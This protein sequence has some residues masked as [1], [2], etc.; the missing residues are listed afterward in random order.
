MP[1][2]SIASGSPTNTDRIRPA[3]LLCQ[4]S[5]FV[6]FMIHSISFSS[7]ADLDNMPLEVMDNII[8]RLRH[9]EKFALSQVNIAIN[10]FNYVNSHACASYAYFC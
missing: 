9:K 5:Q 3:T 2:Y 4:I 1:R 10:N 6:D 7:M 8:D